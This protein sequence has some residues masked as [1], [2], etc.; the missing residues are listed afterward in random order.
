[1]SLEYETNISEDF[2]SDEYVRSL[3]PRGKLALA[4]VVSFYS[5][6]KDINIE[7]MSRAT[8]LDYSEAKDWVELFVRLGIIAKGSVGETA[9]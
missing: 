6:K 4:Y 7:D 5:E 8:G 3:N 2:W 9:V 1:M